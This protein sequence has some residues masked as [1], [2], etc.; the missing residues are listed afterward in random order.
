MLKRYQFTL[1]ENEDFWR[2]YVWEVFDHGRSTRRR[3][4]TTLHTPKDAGLDPAG[5]LRSL[6]SELEKPL[7]QRWQPRSGPASPGGP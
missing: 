4:L 6:A 5:V 2:C 1:V 3:I 7:L